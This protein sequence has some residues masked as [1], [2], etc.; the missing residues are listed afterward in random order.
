MQQIFFQNGGAHAVGTIFCIARNYVAHIEELHNSKP[1]SPVIFCKPLNALNTSATVVLPDY[2]QAVH[3]E[4]ELVVQLGNFSGKSGKNIAQADAL[5]HITGIALGLDLTARDVQDKLKSQG[6]P[7]ELAKGF[8]GAACL[9]PFIKP[10]AIDNWQNIQFS[11]DINGER[12][13]SGDSALMIFPIAEQ[14]SFL[15]R[16]FTLRDGDLLFTGTPSGVGALASG[17][18]LQADLENGLLRIEWRVQ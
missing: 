1:D 16:H 5:A 15:S 8:D 18:K 6:Y 3:F 7:W 14:I 9:S 17:D 4:T 10:E 13:Q 11:L 12:R 2:S